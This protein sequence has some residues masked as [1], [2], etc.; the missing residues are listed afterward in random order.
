MVAEIGVEVGDE[1][2]IVDD[3]VLDAW[4][5]VVKVV[6]DESVDSVVVSVVVEINGS[7]VVVDGG[8]V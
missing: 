1:S 5:V 8:I 4:V 6:V 7:G 2:V 3:S